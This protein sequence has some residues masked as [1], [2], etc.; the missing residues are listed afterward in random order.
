MLKPYR[1]IIGAAIIVRVTGSPVGV[2]I[3]A[4]MKISRIAY[5]VL[6]IRNLG[7]TAPTLARKNTIVGI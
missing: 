6:V 7:V 4:N 1:A 3:A 2:K 5:L